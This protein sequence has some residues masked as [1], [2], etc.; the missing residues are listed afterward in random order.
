[1]RI[2]FVGGRGLKSNY[3]GVEHAIREIAAR[4]AGDEA[5]EIDVYGRGTRTGFSV[6]PIA[7]GL[8][9]IGAPEKLSRFSGNAVLAFFCCLY[10][11]IFRRPR[12]LLLFASGPSLLAILA[13]LR[14]V[15][16]IAALRA[17]DSQRDKWNWLNV[18]VL[19]LGEWSALTIANECTVNSL[20][21]YRHYDGEKRKLHYIPNG[22]SPS[23]Q[24]SDA[25]LARYGL[26]PDNYLLF[27]ARLDPSKRLHVLLDAYARLPEEGRIPLVIAGGECR[28][29]EYEALLVEKHC[30]GVQFIGHV[31]RD[32][33]DPLMRNCAIFLLPSINEGMSNSLLA[34]MY[35]G[36]CVICSDIEPNRDVVQRTDAMFRT[37]DLGDLAEKLQRYCQDPVA[38]QQ[39]GQHL[40][41]IAF[42]QFSWEATADSYRDLILRTGGITAQIADT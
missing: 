10:A 25:V 22:A 29:L 35:A 7:P 11:L 37:D 34:A 17:I 24:G 39:C 19:R 1:M 16:V 4:L 27:A 32:V 6:E 20:E 15:K 23:H 38:R 18:W 2:A 31:E 14:R 8:T 9:I 41:Q 12:V 21:M 28:S 30:E 40:Q 3:G 42:R 13:R 33:L 5:L 36:R 26:R